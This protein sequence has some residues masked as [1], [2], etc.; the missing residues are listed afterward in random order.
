MIASLAVMAAAALMQ[1]PPSC[2]ALK[3]VAR[4]H[5]TITNVEFV[6]AGA[7]LPGRGGRGAPAEPLP[8]HCRVA[9]T[10]TPSADSR[11]EMELWLPT[12]DWNGKFLAVGNGGWAGSIS[13]A[14]MA[15]G[16]RRGYATA[17]NDT[18][19]S[20]ASAAFAVGHPEKLIDFGYRAMHEMTVQSKA[21]IQAFYR[22]AP[23]LSYYQG[24][25]T[26]GRQGM[27]EAQ[28]YPDDF[29]AIIAGAPVYNMVHLNVSQVALQVDMLRDP[30]RLVPPA[31]VKRLAE[32]VVTA[33]DQRDGVKDGIVSEPRACRFDPSVLACKA[34][35]TGACLTAPQVENARSAYAPLTQKGTLVYPGRSPGFEEGWRIPTPG[36]PLNPL[37]TDMVR[38]VGRQDP[39]WDPMTFDLQADLARAL[40]NGGFV[41]ANDPDLAAFK[42]RGGKL[43]LYHG[44][45]DPGPAPE[46]TINYLEA[47]KAKLGGQE[48]SW[49]RAFLMPGV[50]HCG[51]GVGPD[52]ADFLGAL[53]RWREAG[54]APARITA[55]RSGRGG[56]PPMAR[57][58]CPHPQV[59]RYSGAGSTDDEKN[60]TC[61]AP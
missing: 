27:M 18:G 44:W 51:G 9:A 38:Y 39:N 28:R 17:S 37:F 22:R 54:E 48:D 45:A 60:F 59:A 35:E 56:R 6:P 12:A 19:H 49:I 57:P 43:L 29:D 8:A 58:L 50:G 26:G 2:D 53:E 1:L 7:A 11:I 4:P 14:A 20:G 32:A 40:K 5:L 16:L 41:E 36:A 15:A 47:V 33:C 10:L 31:K 61:V 46:N 24:C 34:G 55:T 3:A 30:A 23:R 21:M 52:Q 25:S 13:T 42:A